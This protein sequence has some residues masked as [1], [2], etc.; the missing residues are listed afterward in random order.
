[1]HLY[2][3]LLIISFGLL[4]SCTSLVRPNFTQE[5]VELRPGQYQ[6]DKMHSFLNFR[7]DHLGLSKII[8]RFNDFEATLDF[9]P[10]NPTAMEL[11]GVVAA[12]SIDVNNTDF[13]NT[14]QESDWLDSERFPQIVFASESV[15]V[16]DDNQFAVNG[17]LSMRGISKP[18]ILEA[19][20]N[21]GADNIITRKYTIGFQANAK[22]LRSEFGMDTFTAFAGD[23]I[24]IELHG[25]FLRQ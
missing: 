10:Q 12:N 13:Q 7:V 11:T 14:L 5:L 2:L 1:M 6:L 9:D 19:R 18:L 23:E 3:R 22:I 21:G 8:G 25:E 4:G 16:T 17:T 20:F 24:D 15:T